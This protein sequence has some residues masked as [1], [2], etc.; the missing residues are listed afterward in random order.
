V[1]CSKC[2]RPGDFRKGHRQC[3]ECER[4]YGRER[5]SLKKADF[6]AYREF[7][8]K[9]YRRKNVEICRRKKAERHIA[10][11]RLKS[12]PCKDCGLSYPPYVMDFDHR[13]PTC[14]ENEINHL[15]NKTTAPWA[16]ILGEIAK[17]DVVCVRCHRMRTWR[18]PK[19][20]DSRR[21]LILQLKD[22]P[23][24]DCGRSFHYCQMDFDHVRGVKV[25]SVSQ[26]KSCKA[27]LAEVAKCEVVCANCHRERT[28]VQAKGALRTGISEIP[29]VWERNSSGEV[30]TSVRAPTRRVLTPAIRPW[31]KFAGKLTDREVATRF[32]TSPVNVCTYRKK[33]GIPS[34]RSSMQKQI[35]METTND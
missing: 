12:V 28:Q 4:A 29:M 1:I 21:E 13:D 6:Q 8:R 14:K 26:M 34:F 22:K 19:V 35:C 20:I 5:Y 25:G 24:A 9:H 23:C 2:S 27:I 3:R 18:P 16:R 11:D 32:S 30:Q 7:N 31:H 33:V 10:V 15:L 17:C